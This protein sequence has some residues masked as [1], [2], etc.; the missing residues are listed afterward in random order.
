MSIKK[1]YILY[2][3]SKDAE[4]QMWNLTMYVYTILDIIFGK[5][6]FLKRD[7]TAFVLLTCFLV[8]SLWWIFFWSILIINPEAPYC[9]DLKITLMVLIHLGWN[10]SRKPA[11]SCWWRLTFKNWVFE[12]GSKTSKLSASSC[13]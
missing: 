9:K 8:H 4:L 3:G 7:S 6:Q 10:T 1:I 12:R 13:R 2:L 5:F 11:L